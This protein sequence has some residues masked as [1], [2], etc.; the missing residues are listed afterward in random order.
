MISKSDIVT[1]PLTAETIAYCLANPVL[2]RGKKQTGQ[3]KAIGHAVIA[4]LAGISM[5]RFNLQYDAAADYGTAFMV[6]RFAPR[7]TVG[8]SP[9]VSLIKD[10]RVMEKHVMVP[11]G[12][13]SMRSRLDLHYIL[14]VFVNG[15]A[16]NDSIEEVR[17]V[18]AAGWLPDKAMTRW[19]APSRA[20]LA[21]EGSDAAIFIP[22]LLEPV[23]KLN[24][25]LTADYI[26]L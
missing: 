2:V 18:Y 20:G 16:A 5:E 13:I 25:L 17:E 1:V 23:W 8:I 4:H 9:S 7:Q 19:V 14:A 6:E 3:L 24:N 22:S 26:C 15:R 12:Q 10:R 21:M 11:V